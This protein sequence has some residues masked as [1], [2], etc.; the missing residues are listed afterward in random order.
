[1]RFAIETPFRDK[2]SPIRSAR[3]RGG[4]M[5]QAAVENKY[6]FD[7]QV[8][9]PAMAGPGQAIPHS[10]V[11][12]TR[13]ALAGRSITCVRLMDEPDL[14]DSEKQRVGPSPVTYPLSKRRSPEPLCVQRCI[15]YRRLLYRHTQS[16]FVL[17]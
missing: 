5:S 9:A 14:N 16:V 12:A 6:G 1:M 2:G 7:M 10:C 11:G 13:P 17:K 15:T 3:E 8:S 4:P